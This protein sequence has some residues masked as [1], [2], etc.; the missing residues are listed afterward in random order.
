MPESHLAAIKR[1]LPFLL[2]ISGKILYQYIETAAPYTKAEMELLVS[3]WDGTNSASVWYSLFGNEICKKRK[4]I[5]E[6]KMMTFLAWRKAEGISA[7][8]RTLPKELI[9][10]IIGYIDEEPVIYQ[11][12]MI[13]V[14]HSTPSSIYYP[15]MKEWLERYDWSI[16]FYAAAASK[17]SEAASRKLQQTLLTMKSS[18]FKKHM[19][20]FPPHYYCWRLLKVVIKYGNPA[21]Q[22]A[23]R[24]D[25]RAKELSLFALKYKNRQSLHFLISRGV[26]KMPTRVEFEASLKPEKH[27]VTYDEATALVADIRK[28]VDM[29]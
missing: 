27:K 5:G 21:S 4:L 13:L 26:F 29:E 10:I 22:D 11:L 18:F 1:M 12:A 14:K 23:I 20:E 2:R 7:G 28:A 8:F 16:R 25:A 19:T 17:M 9:K 15:M 24:I 3:C 6:A